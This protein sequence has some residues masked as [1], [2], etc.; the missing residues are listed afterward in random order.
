M[1]NKI[2]SLL[3]A[4]A[5]AW[6]GAAGAE[7]SAP[8]ATAEPAHEEGFMLA[9]ATCGDVYDLYADATDGEGRDP[10]DVKEAQDDILYLVVWVHGYLSGR[11]GFD[12]EKRPL[13]DEGIER[14]VGEMDKVCEPDRSKRFLDAA[15]EIK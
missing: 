6:C 15:M 8:A 1:K 9:T 14:I 11:Y 3:F 10:N 7:E 4:S 2:R 5:V 13:G 12:L